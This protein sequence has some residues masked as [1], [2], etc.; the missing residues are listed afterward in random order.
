MKRC[1]GPPLD[2][3]NE[4]PIGIILMFLD[5]VSR[6]LL[7][8]Y[9]NERYALV[10]W[11]EPYNLGL[12]WLTLLVMTTGTAFSLLPLGFLFLLGCLAAR[13]K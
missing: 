11:F 2:T 1:D 6:R 8:R 3:C 9:G 13:S 7:G 5:E 4:D 12:F 10:G